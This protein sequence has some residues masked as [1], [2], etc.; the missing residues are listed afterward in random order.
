MRVAKD[1]RSLK[2]S[3]ASGERHQGFHA[4]G[5]AVSKLVAPIVVTRGGGILVRLKADWAAIVGAD[6]AGMTW[7]VAF[8]RDGALKLRTVPTAALE[9]Q[10]R[11]P[12][13]IDRVN[14]YLGRAAVS[15]LVLVQ[16]ALP[17]AP[18]PTS[19]QPRSLSDGPPQAGDGLLSGIADP[20]LR[21]ALGRLAAAVNGA[22][23]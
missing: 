2:G 15:R 3:G 4:V 12:L 17:L 7:P 9:L 23:R 20:G 19:S 13:V 6:W 1:Q 21:T 8:G 14:L 18:E 11:A 22:A 5:Q 16:A 10:H